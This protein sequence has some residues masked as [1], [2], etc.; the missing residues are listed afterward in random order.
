MLT[1]SVFGPSGTLSGLVAP[2][3]ISLATSVSAGA[4]E[5]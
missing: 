5:V 3:A 1:S 4:G 2:L